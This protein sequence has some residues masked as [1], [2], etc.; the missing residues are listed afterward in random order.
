MKTIYH[1][2]PPEGEAT[3]HEVDLERA[4]DYERIKEIVDEHLGGVWFEH[5]AVLWAGQRTDMFVDETGL[6]KGLPLNPRASSIY[7]AATRND[8]AIIVGTA[9]LFER[10]IWY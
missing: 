10:R 5:V 4:P 1:V 8:E 7:G 6:L 9:I 3:R 2:I